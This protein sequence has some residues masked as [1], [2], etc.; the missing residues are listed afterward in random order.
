MTDSKIYSDIFEAVHQLEPSCPL[1]ECKSKG[2]TL[3]HYQQLTVIGLEDG[4]ITA[5]PLS[6][7]MIYY[8]GENKLYDSC[9]PNLYR[10]SDAWER[11]IW[12]IRTCDF[13]LF[14]LEHK[15]IK[16]RMQTREKVDLL[17]LAQHYGF[18]THMLDVTNDIVVAAYF[19]TH[20][21]DPVTM[22]ME[23]ET[24]G[25]GRLRWMLGMVG[26]DCEHPIRVFGDQ[27]FARPRLQSGFGVEMK[28]DEDFATF[29]GHIEFK[30]SA[31][32]SRIMDQAFDGMN[33]FFPDEQIEQVAKQI[34]RE[35]V[36]TRMGI[37]RY[38]EKSGKEAEELIQM[39][40]GRGIY[41]VD[42]P[43]CHPEIMRKQMEES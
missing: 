4:S 30:Q 42:A 1:C 2:G 6:P 7:G 13:E 19:A 37:E 40:K 28:E 29:S 31:E 5:V 36:V 22:R 32:M 38:A 16:C 18:P 3:Q 8:R 10:Y 39:V 21:Y 17:A 43:L 20:K 35:N 33:L 24:E 26:K 14:L 9:R 41:V 23:T 27:Y 12:Q 25:T 34:Q 15:E 11:E